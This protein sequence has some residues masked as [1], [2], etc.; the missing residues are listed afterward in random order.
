MSAPPA[1]LPKRRRRRWPTTLLAGLLIAG[2]WLAGLLEFAAQIPGRVQDPQTETDAIIV[3]TGGADRLQTGLDLLARRRAGRLFVSGVHRDADL[4]A[5]LA[6]ITLP[7]GL[8]QATIVCCITLDHEASNTVENALESAQWMAKNG[9]RSMRLVTADYHMPRSLYEFRRVM[10]DLVILPHP[11]FPA[12]VK[13]EEWWLWPGTASLLI[14]EYH[15][16]LVA[17]ARGLISAGPASTP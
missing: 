2:V 10:P 17:L 15:K 6:N 12:E 11:V 5:L 8:E 13:R 3:L 1:D 14:S 4:D 16:Y 9:F 7:P